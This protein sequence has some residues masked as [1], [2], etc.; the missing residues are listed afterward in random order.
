MNLAQ[1]FVLNAIMPPSEYFPGV[2][3]TDI[4]TFGASFRNET[5]RLMRLG[6]AL[7][8]FVFI[9]SPVF[10]V[11]LPLPAF[12]LPKSTLQKHAMRIS[13][14]PIYGIR[15]LM[16]LAKFVGGLCW[17][18]DPRVRERMMLEPLEPDPGTWKASS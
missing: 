16:F 10:T 9:I 1:R 14:S 17:G 5:P 8:C 6:F 7:A 3:D 13:D 2:V 4:A 18:R 12:F 11:Y 15:Q